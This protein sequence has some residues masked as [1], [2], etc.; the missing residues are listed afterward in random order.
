VIFLRFYEELPHESVA[1]K[2]GRSSNAVR[3]IQFRAL[4]RLRQLLEASRAH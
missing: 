2:L 4:S 3:A 1:A